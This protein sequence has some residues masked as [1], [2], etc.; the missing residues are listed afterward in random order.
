M[1]IEQVLANL[2]SNAAKYGDAHA[3]IQLRIDRITT[4]VQ[5]AVT[6]RGK[7]IAADELPRLFDRFARSPAAAG[8]GVPGLGLGL[9]I[10]KEIV[11]AHGGRIWAESEPGK[12]TTFHV[13]L[14]AAEARLEAA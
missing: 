3:P 13:V 6:N 11:E 1:R 12:R 14:P 8:S 2:L 10:T 7:G 5:I 4:E 9:Y